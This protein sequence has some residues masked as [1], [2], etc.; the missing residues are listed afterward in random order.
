MDVAQVWSEHERQDSYDASSPQPISPSSPLESH[1]VQ[2][3]GTRAELDHQ[4]EP[5][6]QEQQ[7]R[8]KVNVKATVAGLGTQA[9]LSS[10]EAPK[11]LEK[12]NNTPLK[13]PDLLSPTEKRKSSWEKYSELIMPALEEE[14]TPNPSPMPT[15]NKR[16]EAPAETKEE[17]VATTNPEAKGSG[18][19][20]VDY[21]PID[22]LSTTLDPGGVIKVSPSD[23]ITFGETIKFLLILCSCSFKTSQTMLFRRLTSDLS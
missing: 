14:W 20:K 11:E 6:K 7:E 1:P 17:L 13:L 23:L 5:G 19:R 22:L 21:L 10:V 15:L 16:P 8:P 4:R 3:M 12:E 2:L 18:E 9:S